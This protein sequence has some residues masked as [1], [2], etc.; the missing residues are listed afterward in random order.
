MPLGHPR[1]PWLAGSGLLVAGVT[2]HPATA[3]HPLPCNL[4]L[5]TRGRQALVSGPS[6]LLPAA[7]QATG[8][9]IPRTQLP[10]AVSVGG[11]QEPLHENY[12]TK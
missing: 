1:P 4:P 11:A 8:A 3:P 2:G 5:G 7:L 10:G 12:G 6:Q 9:P